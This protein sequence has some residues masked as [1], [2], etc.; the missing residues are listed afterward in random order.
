M[1]ISDGLTNN[2]VYCEKYCRVN[3]CLGCR[4]KLL[5]SRK[6][7]EDD[8]MR[9]LI[10]LDNYNTAIGNFSNITHNIEELHHAHLISACKNLKKRFQD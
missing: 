1:D 7:D 10:Q 8:I 9:L 4:F 2:C 6:M 5:R 3:I